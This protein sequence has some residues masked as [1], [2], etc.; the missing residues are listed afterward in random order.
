MTAAISQSTNKRNSL[1]MHCPLVILFNGPKSY[2]IHCM[3]FE[4]FF[5]FFE[6]LLRKVRDNTVGNMLENKNI[7]RSFPGGP[8]VKNPPAV[9]GTPV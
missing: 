1:S 6:N 4:N 5:F 3:C 8:V 2:V 9:Q 7:N